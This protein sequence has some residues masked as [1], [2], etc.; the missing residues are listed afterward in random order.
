MSVLVYGGAGALGDAV[1]KQ[2]KH[3]GKKV[4]SVDLADCTSADK[5]IKIT[6]DS[7]LADSKTVLKELNGES[8]LGRF[9]VAYF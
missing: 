1:V 9:A 2:C 5:C 3:L 4:F 7:P 6:G 8:A